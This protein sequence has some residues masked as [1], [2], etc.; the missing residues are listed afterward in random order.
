MYLRFMEQLR[1]ITA[2]NVEKSII[3]TIFLIPM[4]QFQSVNAGD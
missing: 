1:E 4:K 3:Q 2:V